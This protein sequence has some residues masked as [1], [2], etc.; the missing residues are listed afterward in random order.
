[1][2]RQMEAKYQYTASAFYGIGQKVFSTGASPHFVINFIFIQID[3]SFY[4]G[5]NE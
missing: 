4:L 2:N 1:M 5:E 3:L